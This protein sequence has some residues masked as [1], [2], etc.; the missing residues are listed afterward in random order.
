MTHFDQSKA[1]ALDYADALAD[2]ITAGKLNASAI[3]S[4]L[5]SYV[6]SAAF[7]PQWR[8]E[9][10]ACAY[11]RIVGHRPCNPVTAKE[12]IMKCSKCEAEAT[13]IQLDLSGDALEVSLRL[14]LH[15]V[16][17]ARHRQPQRQPR[18]PARHPAAGVARRPQPR[19]RRSRATA[20]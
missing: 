20:V 14:P 16:L 15:C 9:L 18:N 1:A 5:R 6:D 11:E 13:C 4:L 8:E 12:G 17:Q 7:Y 2:R 3:S 19:H 10:F